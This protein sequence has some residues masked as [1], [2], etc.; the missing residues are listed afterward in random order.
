MDAPMAPV[1]IPSVMV[2]LLHRDSASDSCKLN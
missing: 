2:A 1:L